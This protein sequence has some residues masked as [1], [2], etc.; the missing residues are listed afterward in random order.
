M[1]DS[2]GVLGSQIKE[3]QEYISRIHI[4]DIKDRES[5]R[6][7]INSMISS[8]KSIETEA[9]QLSRALKSDVKFQGAWGELTLEKILEI[10]GLEK[11]REYFTQGGFKSAEGD[12]QRPDVVVNLP[13]NSCLII[14]SKVSLKSYFEFYNEDRKDA[15]KDLK[16]S[17]QKHIDSL[18]KKKYQN[19]HELNSPEFVYLF[20]PIEGVYAL[21]LN[22][23]PELIDDSIKK[24]VILVSP[25]NLMANLKTVSSLWRLDKQSK[26]AEEMAIKAG[27]MY[28]KFVAVIDDIDKIGL[29][30][31]R[32]ED[33]RQDLNR[34]LSIGKGNLI[35]RAEELKS[36]GAKTSKN[37]SSN[38]N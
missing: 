16:I 5:L 3:Y 34:K 20:I 35:S 23:Y 22:S 14:D 36:L 30:L 15:L 28:D 27:A 9:G 12:T 32:A 17:I 31:K 19:I 24:N 26:N 1:K 21:M 6:E 33:S 8:A 18:S 4:D 25:I 11:G 38:L 37:I 13:N 10:S 2:T 29:H 7:K